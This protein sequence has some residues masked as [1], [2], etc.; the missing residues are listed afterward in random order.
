MKDD[1]KPVTILL[2][3]DTP[4]DAA[5]L[6]EALAQEKDAA[7]ELVHA[8]SLEAGLQRLGERGVDLVLLDL[9]LPDSEGIETLV[10][11]RDRS[12]R[13]P[14][15]VLTASDDDALALQALQ[16]GAQDYLVKAYVQVYRH[17]LGRAIRYALERARA[18]RMKDEFVSTVSHE[19]RTP[20]ATIREFTAILADRIAGPLTGDQREYL[21]IIQANVNRLTR[22]IDN[23]LDMA[24]IEAGHILLDKAVVEVGPLVDQTI[25]S[26][27]PL[28]H[29][30]QIE[31]T[32]K[33]SPGLP[34]LFADAD[35]VTQILL[36]LISNAI[37]FTDRGGRITV[38]VEEQPNDLEF[39]VADS[40][41][42]IAADDLPK[43]FEKFRQVPSV[44]RES[45]KGTGLGLAI[46][47]RLVELHGGRIW[48]TSAPG[49]GSTFSFALPK[50]HPEELFHE[51][52]KLGI[53]Q[54]K[55]EQ[56][57]F[58]IVVITVRAIDEL[59]ALHGL[60]ETTRLLKELEIVLRGVVRMR[61]GGD[62]V[63]RWRRGEVVVILA[64]ADKAG[65]QAMAGRIEQVVGEWSFTVGSERRRI[66]VITAT[67]T[68]PDDG[69]TEQELLHVTESRLP[70]S[71]K[72]KTHVMVVDDEPKIRQFIKE[73]LEL[74]D[75]DVTTAASGP[76]ALQ[77]LKRT[78]VDLIL[79]DLMMPVMDGY[80]VYHLLRENPATKD[81]PVIIVTAKGERKDRQLGLEGPTYNYLAKPFQIEELLAKVREALH[82]HSVSS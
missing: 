59:K 24:K 11:V 46:S 8:A 37:K 22:M 72:P 12:P 64:A 74:Q 75:Y 45:A 7:F 4:A 43:L 54:A 50:Y 16:R 66:P 33:I 27:R 30:K 79:M 3:E 19:L 9:V 82:H 55:R 20:L 67:A 15:V 18:D 14:I 32:A 47:K 77:Q 13:V 36:N 31:M 70:P 38:T 10:K 5:I 81:V 29:N 41:I 25:Q 58:S 6:R 21:G 34:V 23:L 69:T 48:V 60:E 17:L 56:R 76:D 71:E 2:I 51:Y 78:R 80:E 62:V 57:R 42:G 73:V 65:A 53:E 35:K 63:V 49:K 52:F 39:S 26:L 28:A 44:S 68:Y 1:Q 40:G 61:V